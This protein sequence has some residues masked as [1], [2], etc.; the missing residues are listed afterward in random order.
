M[1]RWAGWM[2]M[3]ALV[4][5]V[6]AVV[7]A[8]GQPCPAVERQRQ[9]ALA[10]HLAAR[11]MSVLRDAKGDPVLGALVAI[12]SSRRCPSPLSDRALKRALAIFTGPVTELGH[13]DAVWA[14]AFSPDGKWLATGSGDG[15]ARIWSLKSGARLGTLVAHE[16]AQMLHE[17]KMTAMTPSPDARWLATGNEDGAARIWLWRPSDLITS[18]CSRLPR[19]LTCSEWKLFLPEEPYRETCRRL[20]MGSRGLLRLSS[21]PAEPPVADRLPLPQEWVGPHP[22]ASVEIRSG[23]VLRSP[24]CDRAAFPL[25]ESPHRPGTS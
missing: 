16:V 8:R 12:E 4:C 21:A 19:N 22:L 17:G 7:L 10:Q 15:T 3:A 2:A 6:G 14:L 11:A 13:D 9:A 24:E 1:L 5:V 18:L 25:P 20:S 23:K